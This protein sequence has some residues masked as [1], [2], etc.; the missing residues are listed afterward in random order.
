[1]MSRQLFTVFGG[2]GFLGRAIVRRLLDSGVRVR[3]AVREPPPSVLPA[4]MEGVQALAC[5]VSDESTVATALEGAAGAV[6]AVGLYVERRA[7]TFDA[8]HVQGAVHIARQAARART[9]KLVHISGIGV[10][11]ES[12]SRYVRARA[13][14]ERCVREVFEGAT[15]L[16]PSV[17]FRPGDAFVLRSAP[18]RHE[19]FELFCTR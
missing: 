2:T 10:D 11:P 15:I 12:A 16:R 8:V 6:N 4:G 7:E 18:L 13:L 17:L 19:H 1:M 5:D 3:I 14:S 9:G